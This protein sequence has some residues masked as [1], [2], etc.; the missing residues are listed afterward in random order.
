MFLDPKETFFES[1]I[2]IFEFSRSKFRVFE[3]SSFGK[4]RVFEFSSFRI[5]ENFEFSSFRV[6]AFLENFEFSSFRVLRNF[7]FSSFEF[8]STRKFSSFF[9]SS[10]VSS[11]TLTTL[12][13]ALIM[14]I[15]CI[16][17]AATDTC[18]TR[19]IYRV[20]TFSTVSRRQIHHFEST[21]HFF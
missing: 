10:R 12:M 1:E 19:C 9:E 14:C 6:F 17:V 20:H 4:F 5:L 11:S 2:L 16:F 15:D 13:R 7:E 18:V 21:I 3:F 8:D